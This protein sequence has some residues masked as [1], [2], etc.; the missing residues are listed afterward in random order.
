MRILLVEDEAIVRFYLK[1]TLMSIN[2]EVVDAKSGDE[3]LEQIYKNGPFD[4]LIT[5]IK[6]KG[7]D[8]FDL[9]DK[10]D[11]MGLDIEIIVESAY[12]DED[13]RMHKYKE[14]VKAFIKKP[15]DL[16]VLE[17]IVRDSDA[18]HH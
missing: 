8:G 6:M 11:E 7:I 12:V 13:E 3:A 10:L 5:D 15:I 18:N 4:L 9:I 1:T 14:R 16:N 2:G 17:A